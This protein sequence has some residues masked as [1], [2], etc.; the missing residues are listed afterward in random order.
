MSDTKPI[1]AKNRLVWAERLAWLALLLALIAAI[2]GAFVTDLYRDPVQ[3]VEWMR[4]NDIS[5][6]V[7]ILPFLLI[8][9]WGTARGSILG[10]L[11]TLGALGAL[12]YLY[13]YLAFSAVVTW[14]TFLHI[15]IVGVSFWAI[16]LTYTSLDAHE[17]EEVLKARVP[18]WPTAGFLFFMAAITIAHWLPIIYEAATSG[19]LPADFITYE[20]ATNPL[21]TIE[22]AFIVPLS[23]AAGVRLIRHEAGGITFAVPLIVLYTLLNV[24]LL[25]SP[26]IFAIN[27]QSLDTDLLVFGIVF[28][29][30]PLLL[31]LPIFFRPDTRSHDRIHAAGRA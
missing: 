21:M 26:I 8:S 7:A 27:G 16:V 5:V 15:A 25:L 17:A 12:F 22:L 6:L 29:I 4:V 9:L 18:R 3:L 31:L 1:T 23:L 24:G 28:T 10:R 14:V 11:V 30:L 20:W 2:A 13:M 19:S